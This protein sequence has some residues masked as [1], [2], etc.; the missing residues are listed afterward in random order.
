MVLLAVRR[1][2]GRVD[3]LPEDPT[4]ADFAAA[5]VIVRILPGSGRLPA[6]SR[7]PAVPASRGYTDD[8]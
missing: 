2:D 4:V 8:R 3:L 1:A 5:D 7:V 6:G